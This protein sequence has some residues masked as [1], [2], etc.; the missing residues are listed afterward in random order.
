[1]KKT[2]LLLGI[3]ILFILSTVSPLSFGYNIKKSI[4]SN[5]VI[6]FYVGG[7]G[8]GNYTKI[9]DAIDNTTNGDTVFVYDDSSPYYE[10]VMVNKSINLVGEDKYSTVIDGNKS[11]N[12]INIYTDWINISGFTIQNSY[13]C[14]IDSSCGIDIYS[15]NNTIDNN[16]IKSNIYNGITIKG[17][18]NTISCNEIYNN[19][20]YSIIITQ[21]SCNSIINNIISGKYLHGSSGIGISYS[22]NNTISYNNIKDFYYEGISLWKSYNN[23]ISYNYIKYNQDY[24]IGLDLC[25]NNYIIGNNISK[26]RYGI[27]F[28]RSC[29]NTIIG[30]NI[31]DDSISLYD[32]CNNN[33]IKN[34]IISYGSSSITKSEN[35]SIIS[36]IFSHANSY[37]SN[38]DNNSI[39]NN[40]FFKGGIKLEDSYQN[41]VSQNMVND[42]PLVY[43]EDK[44]DKVIDVDAGQIILVNCDNFT[45]Q[46][47]DLSNTNCGIELE[48]TDNCL[49]S[50]NILS[51]NIYGGLYLVSSSCNNIIVNN[52]ITLN[53]D[54]SI[55]LHSLCNENIIMFNNVIN[56]KE[57]GISIGSNN[58]TIAYN[59]ISSNHFH[60]IS[61]AGHNNNITHNIISKNGDISNSG[62]GIKIWDYSNNTIIKND[63]I[64]NNKWGIYFSGSSNN[65]IVGNN[66]SLNKYNGIRLL[67]ATDNH[68]IGNNIISNDWHGIW[69]EGNCRDNIIYNNNLAYNDMNANDTTINDWDNGYPSGGNYWDDY[70]GEDN[71]GDGIGD[72]PYTI[73]GGDNEDRYPLMEPWGGFNIPPVKPYITG[74]KR[75]KTG[76]EYQYKFLLSDPNFD[77]MYIRVDWGDGTPGSWIGPYESDVKVILSHTWNEN[78]NYTIRAQSKD[79]FG[80]S[81]WAELIVT[82]PRDKTT[83]SFQF[84][85]FLEQFPIFEKLIFYFIK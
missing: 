18:N 78:G 17:S 27:E 32:L 70:T 33:I 72:T 42:K 62:A 64:L 30:N 68:I 40:S 52:N 75:G 81:D 82:M 48:D 45:I 26:N 60:G 7:S 19:Y 74:P 67:H 69:V 6:T 8:P 9:Q 85:R 54:N 21:C 84:L 59:N 34:N 83:S 44:S 79:D 3:I 13:S 47:Q 5:N 10:N 22:D 31:S 35:N 71:N 61:I 12:C 39:I 15:N 41:T 77:A 28:R 25:N 23:N 58:N 66:I 55:R 53:S 20:W 36:N 50:S 1:M 24:A 37:F 2:I 63:I 51:N 46:N 11:G 49:I 65:T 57:H 76:V 14:R 38:S 73:P 16:I 4:V 56:N 29:N 43:F 80:V